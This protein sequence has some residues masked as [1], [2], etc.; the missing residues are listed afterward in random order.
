[1]MS[2]INNGDGVSPSSFRHE[3]TVLDIKDMHES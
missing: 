1:M 2:L 3:Y